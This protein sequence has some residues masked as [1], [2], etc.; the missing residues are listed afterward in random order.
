MLQLVPKVSRQTDHLYGKPGN[1]WEFGRCQANDRK[2]CKET[3]LSCLAI[4]QCSMDV[5]SHL[6]PPV[7]RILRLTKWSQ[8]FCTDIY[9][10]LVALAL[11]PW[12]YTFFSTFISYLR[13]DLI[14]SVSNVRPPI[15][16]KLQFQLNL[17]CRYNWRMTVCSMT[18]VKVKATSPWKSEIWLFSKA[19]S[20]IYNEG[21]Q[22]T[23]DS[24]IRAQ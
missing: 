16:R 15:H 6:V 8:T 10:V 18:R 13:V 14:K 11:Y 2:S 7:L 24:S 5:L 4:H 21:W 20:P 22:M 12:L 3:V 23:T 17:A 1:V 9:N 19:I